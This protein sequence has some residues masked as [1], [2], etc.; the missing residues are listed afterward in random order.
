MNY[1][2]IP[3]CAYVTHVDS[4]ILYQNKK[5]INILDISNNYSRSISKSIIID[6]VP[7]LKEIKFDITEN[8]KK[9]FEEICK[10]LDYKIL[11]TDDCIIISMQFSQEQTFPDISLAEAVANL[12][13][14]RLILEK[15]WDYNVSSSSTAVLLENFYDNSDINQKRL[16][17]SPKGI[18]VESLPDNLKDKL[19]KIIM[20]SELDDI[21]D[22]QELIYKTL[23]KIKTSKI[24]FVKENKNDLVRIFNT[25][26]GHFL[27]QFGISNNVND[28]NN[29][30]SIGKTLGDISKNY[31]S[32]KIIFN[33]NIQDHYVSVI[34]D[35]GTALKN[36]SKFN[37]YRYEES[38]S[39]ISLNRKN[40]IIPTNA[41]NL[42]VSIMKSFP[43]NIQDFLLSRPSGP[44][45]VQLNL[46]GIPKRENIVSVSSRVEKRLAYISTLIKSQI[47]DKYHKDEIKFKDLNVVEQRLIVDYVFFNGILQSVGQIK[48]L[49]TQ[50]A[51][52]LTDPAGCTVKRIGKNN[53]AV[54]H[55][56][57]G[58]FMVRS[59]VRRS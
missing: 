2:N 24:V 19:S 15:F 38:K 20:R 13:D 45:I 39:E 1:F 33:K 17:D 10:I 43:V 16:L 42:G 25:E 35:N 47:Q 40:F 9:D 7:N 57:E 8:K 11:E 48:T 4:Y 36:I 14:M 34:H 54:S 49:Y 37:D 44:P 23:D 52:Y 51:A 3:S 29:S 26:N 21:I 53:F 27:F 55:P 18:S 41:N 12:K 5:I 59:G 22:A 28:N 50:P 32:K 46:P 58:Y 6:G 56:K 31:P 30:Y